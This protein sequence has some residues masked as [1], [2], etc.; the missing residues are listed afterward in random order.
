[1]LDD[2][3]EVQTDPPCSE[4]LSRTTTSIIVMGG[5]DQQFRRVAKAKSQKPYSNQEHGP[6]F[7]VIGEA[8]LFARLLFTSWSNRPLHDQVKVFFFVQV[9]CHKST[10]H[11][12]M[13]VCCQPVSGRQI[14]RFQS[15]Y[16]P[17]MQLQLH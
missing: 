2:K 11:L 17:H 14:L 10:R 9:Q 7:R 12:C 1:M 6:T 8:L 13:F 5:S 4:L 16:H 3:F 15:G